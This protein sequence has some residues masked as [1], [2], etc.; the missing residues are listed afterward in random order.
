M[1]IF[2]RPPRGFRGRTLGD[3]VAHFSPEGEPEPI[4]EPEAVLFRRRLAWERR[5]RL[6][7]HLK[8][9]QV[10]YRDAHGIPHPPEVCLELDLFQY[11]QAYG[12]VPQSPYGQ[13]QGD[14]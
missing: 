13:A 7:E 11:K 2:D 8:A 5:G 10:A 1:A 12:T 14:K 6:P 3:L 4:P 9:A